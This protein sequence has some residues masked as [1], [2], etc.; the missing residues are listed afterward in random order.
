MKRKSLLRFLKKKQKSIR[1][2]NLIMMENKKP[3]NPFLLPCPIMDPHE[4]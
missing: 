2:E 4:S 1:K 3:S